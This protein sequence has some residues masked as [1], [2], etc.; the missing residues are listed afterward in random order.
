MAIPAQLKTIPGRVIFFLRLL[1]ALFGLAAS[2]TVVR[3]AITLEVES[4][5]PVGSGATVST[6][7]DA[8]ASGG[9]IEFLNATA[10]NQTMTL[11]TPSVA[12]GTYQVQFR[13]KT[14]TTRGQH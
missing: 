4:M 13:Y 10:A 8:N 5:S 9:V 1:F 12:A 6:S 3:A 7:N 11:T 14:N 2:T